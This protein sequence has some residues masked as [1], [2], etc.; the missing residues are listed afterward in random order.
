M[1]TREADMNQV[2]D[3]IARGFRDAL[4]GRHQAHHAVCAGCGRSPVWCR[5][6]GSCDYRTVNGVL[7]SAIL[8][9]C[10]SA[11]AIASTFK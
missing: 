4:Q 3:P 7:I 6:L 11:M 9:V 1:I 5:I 2:R 8:L 10:L